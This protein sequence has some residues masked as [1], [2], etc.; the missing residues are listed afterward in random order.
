MR[1]PEGLSM[2]LAFRIELCALV[3]QCA[4]LWRVGVGRTC[5]N[6]VLGIRAKVCGEVRAAM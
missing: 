1:V 6:G 3:K 4:C 2:Q 5:E